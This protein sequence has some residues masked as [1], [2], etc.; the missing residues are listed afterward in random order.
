MQLLLKGAEILLPDRP[1]STIIE[2]YALSANGWKLCC[3][4]A[5]TLEQWVVIALPHQ[6]KEQLL[7]M[8]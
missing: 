4:F 2:P 1:E 6:R 3:G 7:T 5:Y 8:T